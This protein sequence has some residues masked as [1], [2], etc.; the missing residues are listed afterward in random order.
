MFRQLWNDKSFI[1]PSR[2]PGYWQ[3]IKGQKKEE[4]SPCKFTGFQL[5]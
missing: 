5:K 3:E 2:N 4:L 1:Y